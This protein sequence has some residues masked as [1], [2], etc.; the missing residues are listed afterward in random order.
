MHLKKSNIQRQI[1]IFLKLFSTT[2]WSAEY[3]SE[4]KKRDERATT[5]HS[6]RAIH[7]PL[8]IPPPVLHSWK[9]LIPFH[10]T[11][12]RLRTHNIFLNTEKLRGG[13]HGQK[14]II[15]KKKKRHDATGHD[16]NRFLFFFLQQL[17]FAPFLMSR[18]FL[19]EVKSIWDFKMKKKKKKT[20]ILSSGSPT[21]PPPQCLQDRIQ[22]NLTPTA[23]W[24]PDMSSYLWNS[25]L[26]FL[27]IRPE[28]VEEGGEISQSDFVSEFKIKQNK[29]KISTWL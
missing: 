17:F 6:A 16:C 29:T 3:E 14:I 23:P 9:R 25:S 4:E 18:W 15:I 13:H 22:S 8:C 5:R 19:L 28:H 1:Y 21:F 11:D 27:L 20:S 10:W 7:T 12:G 2:C 26:T 24:W